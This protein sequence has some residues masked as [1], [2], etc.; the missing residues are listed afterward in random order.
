MS[1][2]LTLYLCFLMGGPLRGP[3]LLYKAFFRSL[4][5]YALPL[6]RFPCLSVTN[7]TKLERLHQVASRT[8]SRCLSSFPIPL[9]LSEASPPPVQVT[10]THF[11]L[12]SYERALCLPTFFA[13]SCLARLGVKPRLCRSSWRAFAS[14]HPLML[15]YLLG[16]LFLC[17]LPL[18]L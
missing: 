13:I 11:A 2:G 7:I 14:T 4:L 10:L 1:Q 3:F 9:F 5:T 8:I 16:R 15:L 6:L 17:A 18:L 12:S